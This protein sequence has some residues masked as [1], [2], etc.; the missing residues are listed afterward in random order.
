MQPASPNRSEAAD[1]AAASWAEST[2]GK[3][4]S[5]NLDKVKEKMMVSIKPFGGPGQYLRKELA[6]K[7]DITEF[8]KY[9]VD[10]FQEDP[11]QQYE[12]TR[13]L[14]TVMEDEVGSTPPLCLH[15]SGIGFSL[16][17][18]LKPFP[19]YDVF[20]DLT[21]QILKDGFVTATDPLIVSEV[22]P[23]PFIND[24]DIIGVTEMVP[25]FGEIGNANTMK[26]FTL[27]W[28][29]GM[30]RGCCLLTILHL[31]R[32]FQICLEQ[33]FPALHR[34]A[35]KIYVYNRPF[36]N[37]VDEALENM[38]LSLRGSIRKIVN[39][40]QLAFMIENLTKKHGMQDFG[41]FIRK[42]NQGCSRTHAIIGKKA[43]ALKLLFEIA[44]RGQH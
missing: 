8:A 1:S 21:S 28:V 25:V 7:Q 35:G 31:L 5:D 26:P 22:M 43:Y 12:T 32:K 29:K 30:A 27:A 2:S 42:W 39:V 20:N 37:K 18:S 23:S 17:A 4:A 3:D 38:K 40:I 36:G 6:S 24:T 10:E 41:V 34:T 19:T 11:Q 13:N 33:Q 16:D 44:G 14:P 9:L 15:P